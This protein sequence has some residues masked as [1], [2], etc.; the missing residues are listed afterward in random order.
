MAIDVGLLLK[1]QIVNKCKKNAVNNA[2]TTTKK[3]IDIF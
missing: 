1:M 3:I 2:G